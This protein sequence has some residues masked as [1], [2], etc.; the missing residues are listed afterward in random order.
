MR[1]PRNVSGAELVKALQKVGYLVS[2]QTGSHIRVVTQ[3][4]SEHRVTIPNHDF[5]KIG[6]LS[7]ILDGI[8]SH[9]QIERSELL[10]QLKL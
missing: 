1:L 2:R 3:E 7:R 5:L 8:A 10:D 9:L 6:T 4:P